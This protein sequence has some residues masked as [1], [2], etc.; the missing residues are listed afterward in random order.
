MPSAI[1]TITNDATFQ[2]LK[3]TLEATSMRQKAIASNIAN[4]NTPEYRRLD[5]TASFQT[6][7]DQALQKLRDGEMLSST[8]TA[9]LHEVDGG[10]HRL[11]GNNVNF[12][13]EMIELMKNQSKFEFAAEML[14]RKYN[15]IKGA[16]SGQVR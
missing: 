12:D 13:K 7:L 10:L 15:S 16:I 1:P 5:L 6:Q 3:L 9:Q 14:S 8:P 2:S 11:D 4:A